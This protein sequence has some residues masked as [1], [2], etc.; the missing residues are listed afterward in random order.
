MKKCLAIPYEGESPYIFTSYCHKDSGQ[1]YPCLESLQKKGYRIWYDDGIDPGTEWPDVIA[2]HLDKSAVFLAFLSANSVESHNCRREFNFAMME[3]KP[4]LIIILE[5]VSFTPVMKMQL[6]SIQAICR[7]EMDTE[8][9]YYAQLERYTV[10][11]QCKDENALEEEKAEK[12]ETSV[13]IWFLNRK[14]SGEMIEIVG[15]EFRIGR[16]KEMCDYAI[17][18]N[19][20]VS[21]LHGIFYKE[22]DRLSIMDNHSLNKIY[23]NDCVLE[24]EEKKSLQDGDRIELGGEIFQVM[25]KEG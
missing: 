10:L 2:S 24:E 25:K 3:N 12:E 14:S 8:E 11:K 23:V 13:C 5:P 16:K 4:S 15:D 7:Y 21:R 19:H 20:A 6:A 18:D 22:Q 17:E 9:E 1:V